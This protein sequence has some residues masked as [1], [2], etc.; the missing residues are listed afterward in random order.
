MPSCG[1]SR[2]QL[3]EEC[4]IQKTEME[5]RN[6]GRSSSQYEERV[7]KTQ[8][9][10]GSSSPPCTAQSCTVHASKRVRNRAGCTGFSKGFSEKPSHRSEFQSHQGP[11]TQMLMCWRSGISWCRWTMSSGITCDISSVRAQACTSPAKLNWRRAEKGSGLR[12][13]DRL[14]KPPTPTPLLLSPSALISSVFTSSPSP[15]EGP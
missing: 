2:V 10:V 8:T 5:R 6:R 9:C 1:L 12:P 4:R 3:V 11:V 14:E 15:L 7:R 13:L